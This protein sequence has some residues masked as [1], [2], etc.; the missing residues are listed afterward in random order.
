MNE[1]YINEK[2]IRYFYNP[3]RYQWVDKNGHYL[4]SFEEVIMFRETEEGQMLW[5][6]YDKHEYRTDIRF[7]I[8]KNEQRKIQSDY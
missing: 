3:K 7:K 4:D 5:P 1:Y 2:Q 6:Y 8:I